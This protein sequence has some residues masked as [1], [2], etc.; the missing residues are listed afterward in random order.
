MRSSQQDAI[1]PVWQTARSCANGNCV[2]VAVLSPNR[3]AVRDTKNTDGP[4]LE[5][6]RTQWQ[7]FL[8]QAKIGSFDRSPVHLP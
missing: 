1:E 5:F 8:A 4:I 6:N 7:E 2:A 3:I